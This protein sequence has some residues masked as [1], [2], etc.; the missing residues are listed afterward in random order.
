[1]GWFDALTTHAFFNGTMWSMSRS[2]AAV[3]TPPSNGLVH[4]PEVAVQAELVW[5]LVPSRL[6]TNS[7]VEVSCALQPV[8]RRR[9]KTYRVLQLPLMVSH[10][11]NR[12]RS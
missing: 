1:M 10:V 5:T 11:G 6:S 7:L 2:L 12:S 3:Q 9:G 8:K 4:E